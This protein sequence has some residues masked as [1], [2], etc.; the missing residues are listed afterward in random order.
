MGLYGRFV[1]GGII[2]G[3]ACGRV[4]SLV[5]MVM[6][7]IGWYDVRSIRLGYDVRSI[8]LGVVG[9]GAGSGC[10]TWTGMGLGVGNCGGLRGWR[11]TWVA[12]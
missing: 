10:R 11:A 8:C 7:S 6:G 1:I 9:A 3:R 2:G 4:V 12:G 5:G